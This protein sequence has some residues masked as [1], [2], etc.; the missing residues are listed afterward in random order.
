MAI[1]RNPLKSYRSTDIAV[2]RSSNRRKEL[3]RKCEAIVSQAQ[4]DCLEKSRGPASNRG[5]TISS[6]A[7]LLDSRI[8]VEGPVLFI[9]RRPKPSVTTGEEYRRFRCQNETETSEDDRTVLVKE[10]SKGG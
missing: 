6:S 7:E 4:V 10:S 8:F 1:Q 5:S 9:Q 2:C 3:G